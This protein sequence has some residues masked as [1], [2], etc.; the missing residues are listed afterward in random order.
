MLMQVWCASLCFSIGIATYCG[1]LLLQDLFNVGWAPFQAVSLRSATSPAVEPVQILASLSLQF[2]ALAANAKDALESFVTSQVLQWTTQIVTSP[3]FE[4]TLLPVQDLERLLDE[5]QNILIHF[6]DRIKGDADINA[7][8]E[9][10]ALMP[11]VPMILLNSNPCVL[12]SP[13]A[14]TSFLESHIT[15]I[16]RATSTGRLSSTLAVYLRYRGT[17]AQ[18]SWEVVLH[19]IAR[20]IQEHNDNEGSKAAKDI[21]LSLTRHQETIKSLGSSSVITEVVLE[22]LDSVLHNNPSVPVTGDVNL[23][24]HLLEHHGIHWTIHHQCVLLMSSISI[25]AFITED[26][27]DIARVRISDQFKVSAAGILNSTSTSTT[28][29]ALLPL[30]DPFIKNADDI[31]DAS[32]M[33]SVFFLAH[34]GHRDSSATTM[35]ESWK[36]KAPS[37]W[38][39][40]IGAGANRLI[41]DSLRNTEC[42][43]RYAWSSGR[44]LLL[45]D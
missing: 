25:D 23:L 34:S 17:N 4:Q 30:L 6:G 42:P 20:L 14:I 11:T 21:L 41:A 9:D 22:L 13:K 2:Q 15:A 5:L 37:H 10:T 28:L 8:S 35:W 24:K 45:L 39:G 1:A 19:A 38:L 16:I 12:P 32:F 3:V 40:Q 36:K 31:A 44:S 33:I 18:N 26:A 29:P 43:L 27:F 7:V